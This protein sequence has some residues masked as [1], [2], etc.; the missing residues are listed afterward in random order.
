M[1]VVDVLPG[2]AAVLAV[3]QAALVGLDQRIDAATVA[4]G[5]RDADLAPLAARQPLAV[6][7]AG[8]R[9][10]G[11]VLRIGRWRRDELGPGVAAV[12]RGIQPAAWPAA[13]QAPGRAPCLPHAGE[14]HLRRLRVEGDIGGAGVS[15]AEEDALPRLSPVEGAVDAALLVGSER[16][17]ED[18]RVGDVWVL[19]VDDDRADLTF[20]LPDML[21]GLAGVLGLVD[22][23][24]GSDV[25][26]DVRLAGADVDHARIGRRQRNRPARRDRLVVEDRLPDVAAVAPFPHARHRAGGIVGLRVARH[27]ASTADASADR[28]ADGPELETLE[29]VPPFLRLGGKRRGRR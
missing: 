29:E 20:L 21:P 3:E 18:R 16:L 26:P 11:G 22:T 10:V 6:L 14:Q 28:W 2:A 13:G 17:A 25:A 19:R 24:A 7:L 23:V 27:T 1:V 5:D 4:G 8:G 15:V 9:R 12:A